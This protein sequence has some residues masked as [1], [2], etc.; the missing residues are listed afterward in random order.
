[1]ALT[2]DIPSSSRH[3]LYG[4]LAAV[5]SFI[6][7]VAKSFSSVGKYQSRIREVE[8][9][10]GKSDEQLAAMGIKRDEIAHHVFR[11]LYYI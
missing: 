4:V 11:G 5:G 3:R 7:S 2:Y 6:A 1:M 10:S 8:R 9:L